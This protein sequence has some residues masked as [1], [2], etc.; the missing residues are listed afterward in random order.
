MGFIL[1][2]IVVAFVLLP[3]YYHLNLTSIYGYLSHRFGTVTHR[4]GASFFILSRMMGAAAR[5][6][7][8]CLILQHYALSPLLGDNDSTFVFVLIV[9]AVLLFIWLYT[10]RG[11]IRTLVFTDTFQ[12]FCL[13]AAVVLIFLQAAKSL[14]FSFSQALSTVWQDS[15]SRIFEFSDWHSK[16][17][18]VKQF[19]SGI[20]IV[21]VMTGLDQDMMQKNL[22]CKSL[23][24]AQ[25]DLCCYGMLFLPVNFLFLALGILLLLIY[26]KTGTPLPSAPDQ[27]LPNFVATGRLG[28]YALSFFSIGIVASAFASADSALT[29]LTTSFCV[30]ICDI[31]K[32][33]SQQAEK[34]RKLVHFG[35]CAVFILVLLAFRALNNTSVIDAIY[36]LASYTYGPLLGLFAFGLFTHFQVRERFVPLVAIAAPIFSYIA[37]I[38]F[39]RFFHYQFGYEL[40]LFNGFL[41]F[42]G[43]FLLSNRKRLSSIH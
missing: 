27:L 18:F 21:I 11:G 37:D 25:K 23:R 29:A 35:V 20:F 32:K 14:D 4:T 1:G 2:Y 34:L 43:L 33:T 28:Q 42:L 6:Y 36:T 16:Q 12:T 24:D 10:R 38:L 3:L 13:L 19:L 8:V 39:S 40:L 26:A 22:T 41:T 7:I 30:D 15:H 5:L 31:E 9:L 17:H